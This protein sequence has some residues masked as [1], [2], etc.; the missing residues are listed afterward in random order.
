[1][2]LTRIAKELIERPLPKEKIKQRP[3]KAGMTYD[4][5]TPDFVIGLLNVAFDYRW[6]TRIVSHAVYDGTAVV[7]LEL[8]VYDAEGVPIVKQQFGSCEPKK[9]MGPGEAFKSAAS[10]AL[11]KAATLLGVAL[12]LYQDDETPAE[13]GF[14]KPTVPAPSAPSK[15]PAP[16]KSSPAPPVQVPPGTTRAMPPLP[17]TRLAQAGPTS[18]APAPPKPTNPF[19]NG[20]GRTAASVTKPAAPTPPPPVSVPA[21]KSNPF[22]S[23]NE[24]SGPNPTQLNALINLSGRKELSQPDMIALATDP[25]ITDEMGNPKQLFEDLTHA[26][27]IRVIKA[28]QV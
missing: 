27:A 10:D 28:S 3:G 8:T 19:G 24:A 16:P 25:P 1:M 20:G 18:S 11:K 26:E 21:A 9:G 13:S 23:Q 17:N 4:Y 7:G 5:V 2:P 14:K 6:S 15:V 22:A 12:E